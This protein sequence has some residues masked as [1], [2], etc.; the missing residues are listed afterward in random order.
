[1]TAF[2]ERYGF[3]RDEVRL[4]NWRTAPWSRFAFEAVREMAPTAR[5]RC[6]EPRAEDAP[7]PDAGPLSS[8]RLDLPDG[9]TGLA[10]VLTHSHTDRFLVLKSGRAV[11]DW[12]APHSDGTAPHILFSITKSVT[13]LAAGILQD[14]GILDPDAPV[15]AYLDAPEGAAYR[16]ATVRDLLDMR[17][18]LDFDESYLNTDGDYDRYRRAMLWNPQR[19]D[20]R[21]ETLAEVLVSLPRADRPHGGPFYYASPNTDALALVVERAAG[22]RYADLVSRRIW[23]P[24][25]ARAD[26]YVTL[27]AAGSPRG[28]GGMC[29]TAHDLAR[30]GEMVRLGGAGENGRVASAGW[31]EDMLTAGDRQAW[32]D[33]NFS[34]LF[35]AGRYRSGWYQTGYDSGAFCCIGIHGQWLYVDPAAEVTIVRLSSQPLPGDDALD[36]LSLALFRTVCDML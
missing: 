2:R 36:A 26:A 23:Q 4:S 13:G 8:L 9:E 15:S 24:L 19:P 25:G 32:K 5:I 31:I 17:V 16:D 1:M 21:E 10:G 27:D 29:A 3:E 20:R 18:S 12:T 11:V 14:E 30:L 7:P 33:G 28:A 35:R 6:T 34:E 22:E